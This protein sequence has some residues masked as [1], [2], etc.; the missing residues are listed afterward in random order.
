M[1]ITRSRT[2]GWIGAALVCSLTAVSAV[3]L[4]NP[5]HA[6]SYCW[7]STPDFNNSDVGDVSVSPYYKAGSPNSI[8]DTWRT[9]QNRILN[10]IASE[11]CDH[12][13]VAGDLVEGHWGLDTAKT[14]TFGPTDTWEHKRQAVRRAGE[15]YYGQWRHRFTSRNLMVH[16]AVGD[17]EIGDNP[18]DGGGYASFKRN[19]ISTFKNVFADT[20]IAPNKYTR[21]PA[22]PASRT[23]YA[24][25]LNPY[26]FLITIDVFQRTDT[27]V[28]AKLDSQQLAWVEN[29]LQYARSKGAKWVIAQGH[30]P[31]VGPVKK[32]GSSGLMY[33]GGRDSALWK[34]FVKYKLDLYLAGE[35]HDV[36]LKRM[37][38]ITQISH[39]GLFGWHGT[40]YLVARTNADGSRLSLTS[41]RFHSRKL[42]NTLMWQ[43]DTS[44]QPFAKILYDAKPYD[45]GGATLTAD[46]QISGRWGNMTP[47]P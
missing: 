22:G 47:Y 13:L 31:I 15:L 36:T 11:G 8:N 29:Q 24:R 27:D 14:G 35:V 10:A 25:W 33:R 30:T 16:P 44:K 41:K 5:A 32:V 1:K 28:I 43:T 2:R 7:T 38:K 6:A 3:L 34:L 39:G 21:H 19:N 37:D 46:N 4:T 45:A 26:T 40:N 17:H 12:A 42:D 9:S 18:W 20:L 23:A